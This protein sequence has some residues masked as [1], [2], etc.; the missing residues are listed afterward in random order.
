MSFVSL[1]HQNSVK[2]LYTVGGWTGGRYFSQLVANAT[3]RLSLALQMKEF[4]DE[5]GFD[6]VDIDWEYPGSSQGLSCNTVS[7]QDTTNLLQFLAV[8][9]NVLGSKKLITAAVAPEGLLGPNGTPLTDYSMFDAY[10]DYLNLMTYDVSGPWSST[11]GPNSPLQSCLS[12]TGV[13]AGVELWISGGFSAEKILVGIASYGRSFTTTTADLEPSTAPD[14]QTTLL[15]QPK[16]S[17]IPQG[18]SY[19]VTTSGTDACGNPMTSS[20]YSGEWKYASLIEQG[21]LSQDGTTG[22][23]GYQRLFDQCT[24]TPF[25]FNSATMTL[26]TYDDRASASMKAAWA[27]DRGLAG[28]MIFDSTGF[29]MD[30]YSGI[31]ASLDWTMPLRR[32]RRARSF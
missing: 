4:A 5:F 12:G 29:T 15:Y 20:G 3:S 19:D 2:A 1:A 18:D 13:E 14:G 24:S 23:R 22:Q 32:T 25:L 10:L 7:S 26:I 21:I 16:S 11:T 6:G 27:S 9:R 31:Q 8:L 17:I 30:V 28:V